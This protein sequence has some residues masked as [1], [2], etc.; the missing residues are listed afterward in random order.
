M[1]FS[2]DDA[3]KRLP[4]AS[5][6]KWP[7]GVWDIEVFQTGSLLLEMFAPKGTDHQ[8]AHDRDELY[9]VVRGRAILV[10]S[11]KRE[12]CGPGDALFVPAHA[13]H[14][15][16]EMTHDFATWVVFVGSEDES[17]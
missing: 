12:P 8:S 11:A 4:L 13:D 10:L 9:V 6:D 1:P 14:H 5:T 2:A 3:L 15:F 17:A 16:D 7:E